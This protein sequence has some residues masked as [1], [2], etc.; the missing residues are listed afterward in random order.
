MISYWLAHRIVHHRVED[1]IHEH[2]RWEVVRNALVGGNTMR[3]IGIIVLLR[4]SPLLPYETT[5]VLLAM[6]GVRPL[7]Y[8]V[9][10]LIGVAPRTALIVLAASRAERLDF[11]A[12]EAG[13]SSPPV[14]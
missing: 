13:G 11:H 2:P 10:T 1:V 9:G 7:P 14:W 4:L 12:P 3:S 5:N 8:L 6:C